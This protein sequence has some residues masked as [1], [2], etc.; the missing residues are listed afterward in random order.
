MP[1]EL[2]DERIPYQERFYDWFEAGQALGFV[3]E[4]V[5]IMHDG[6]E[7]LFEPGDGVEHD[8]PCI[9]GARLFPVAPS[10]KVRGA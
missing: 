8:D 2:F 7:G 6:I 5:C 10:S 9:P 4:G 3:S 1:L